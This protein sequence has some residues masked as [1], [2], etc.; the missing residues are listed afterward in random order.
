MKLI[1]TIVIVFW[2]W[3][4]TFV[5]LACN[6]GWSWLWVGLPVVGMVVLGIVWGIIYRDNKECKHEFREVRLDETTSLGTYYTTVIGRCVFCKKE[7]KYTN[8]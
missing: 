1:A 4:L 2:V 6:H 5:A 3:L 8:K 7:I